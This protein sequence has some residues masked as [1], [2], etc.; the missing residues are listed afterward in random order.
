MKS[1]CAVLYYR[2][3]CLS[4]CTIIFPHYLI[5]KTIFNKEIFKHKTPSLNFLQIPSQKFIF[6]RRI[7]RIDVLHMCL[8]L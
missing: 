5:K 6:L 3:L 8:S 4:L 1:A 2:V 7:R